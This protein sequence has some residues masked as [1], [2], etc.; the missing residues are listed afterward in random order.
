MTP[1]QLM[2]RALAEGVE[3]EIDG[4]VM[5]SERQKIRAIPRAAAPVAIIAPAKPAP[6]ALSRQDVQDMLS[7]QEA[8]WKVAFDQLRAEVRAP[9][10]APKPA[11]K[12]I[13]F[14]YDGAVIKSA[15]VTDKE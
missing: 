6:P 15:E 1:A 9:K 10:P 13:K 12:V 5:N 14:T 11:K 3:V 7:A 2:R 4:R 8:R